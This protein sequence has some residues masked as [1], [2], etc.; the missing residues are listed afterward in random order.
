MEEA[1]PGGG[2]GAWGRRRGLCGGGG[3]WGGGGAEVSR[4]VGRTKVVRVALRVA[5]GG[6]WAAGRRVGQVLERLVRGLSRGG[7]P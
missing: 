4:W 2:G 1:G 3:A 7:E 6:G 5:G